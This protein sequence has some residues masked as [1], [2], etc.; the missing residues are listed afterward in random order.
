MSRVVVM[1]STGIAAKSDSFSV[2]PFSYQTKVTKPHSKV[3]YMIR[4]SPES[5][6]TC[7]TESSNAPSPS[8]QL[9][10]CTQNCIFHPTVDKLKKTSVRQTSSVEKHRQHPASICLKY[11]WGTYCLTQGGIAC[12]YCKTASKKG[13]K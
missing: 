8:C 5:T 1:G 6:P 2:L 13:Q 11:P 3:N 10:C 4:L 7:S 12:F 9:P